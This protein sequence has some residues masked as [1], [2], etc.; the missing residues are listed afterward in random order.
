MF[1]TGERAD[2]VPNDR[3]IGLYPCRSELQRDVGVVRVVA[4]RPDVAHATAPDLVEQP[5]ARGGWAVRGCGGTFVIAG[6]T[7]GNGSRGFFCSRARESRRTSVGREKAPRGVELRVDGAPRLTTSRAAARARS[8]SDLSSSDKSPT[9]R[10][11]SCGRPAAALHPRAPRRRRAAY[12]EQ[13]QTK[14]SSSAAPRGGRHGRT[15]GFPGAVMTS[16]PCHGRARWRWMIRRMAR[17]RK[18]R[19]FDGAR[20][21]PDFIWS[22]TLHNIPYRNL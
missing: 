14:A 16:S 1:E 6:A 20:L 22:C 9:R 15:K 17:P 3:C 8:R 19:G 11:A 5:N 7:G 4:R 10:A 18:R 2:L 21:Q 13:P 12:P